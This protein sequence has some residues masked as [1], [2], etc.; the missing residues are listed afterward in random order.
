M[1]VVDDRP[2]NSMRLALEAEVEVVVVSPED[3]TFENL[4]KASLVLV[5]YKLDEW[6]QAS[7]LCL[8]SRPPDGL[9]LASVLRRHLGHGRWD[10][11]ESAHRRLPAIALH[12]AELVDLAGHLPHENRHHM[13][14]TL[15]NLEWVFGKSDADRFV[16]IVDL[17]KAMQG[18]A[19]WLDADEPRLSQLLGLDNEASSR[20]LD[21]IES[22]RPPLHEMSDWSKGLAVI[23]W[24]LHRILPY[25]TMLI[26]S[27]H[28]AARFGVLPTDA[29]QQSAD[30]LE[31]CKYKGILAHFFG[32]R[33]WRARV[34]QKIWEGTDG[35]YSSSEQLVELARVWLDPTVKGA[36]GPYPV[37]CVDD[38][39]QST[40]NLQ[41]IGMCVRIQP[42]DWPAYAEPAWMEQDQIRHDP[43]LRNLVMREDRA[44]LDE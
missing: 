30:I 26:D 38:N 28:L 37:V 32:P 31:D 7:N 14:A 42:D 6:Q 34:E 12:T 41:P 35:G 4:S 10:D 22:C 23:R 40:C 15:N 43:T 25:P 11:E 17:S 20:L 2:D 9:A 13:L 5:D 1:L 27:N 3:V 39:F 24:L 29:L 33:W 19:E 44:L 21:D 8:A 16:Q 18:L 36:P